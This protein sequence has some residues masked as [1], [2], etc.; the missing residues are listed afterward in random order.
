MKIQIF[1]DIHTGINY[2][3][4]EDIVKP[5]DLYLDAGDTGELQETLD[6]YDNKIWKNKK[7]CFVAGNHT[8]YWNE[9]E[10]TNKFL[11]NLYKPTRKANVSFLQ[12][13]YIEYPD[14]VIIGTTLWTDYNL[15]GSKYNDMIYC[16]TKI[17]DYRTIFITNKLKMTPEYTTNLFKKSYEYL[18]KTVKKFHRKK[19]IILTHHTPSM[20]SC[21]DIYR[22]DHTSSA[23]ASSLEN[24]IL[25]N[26]NIALWVHG[27][28][29]NS[30]D[31][32]I[33]NT[34]IICNPLGYYNENNHYE[35]KIIDF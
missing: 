9:Y 5:A 33:G 17:N 6:F 25:D 35:T 15:F 30:S 32:M 12:N 29:H 21:L 18:T 24:F 8:Y 7:V 26:P 23:F 1:S 13:R 2:I 31:Y 3:D 22:T 34:R 27:H 19:C 4:P 16:R 10:K 28:V 14:Y 11:R 20:E